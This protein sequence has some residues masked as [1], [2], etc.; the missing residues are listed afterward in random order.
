MATKTNS[1]K[2]W[3]IFRFRERFELG[4]DQRF[5][6]KGPLVYARDYVSA[7]D[8]ESAVYLRQMDALSRRQNGLELEGAWSRIRRAAS[9]RSRAYR[10]YLL[11]ANDCPASDAEIARSVLFCEPRRASRILKSL[12]EIGL[13]EQVRCPTFDLSE[14]DAPK[15]K[16]RKKTSQPRE[17]ANRRNGKSGRAKSVS[18]ESSENLEDSRT[19]LRAEKENGKVSQK[20][21]NTGREETTRSPAT[22]PSPEPVDPKEPEGGQGRNAHTAPGPA[23]SVKSSGPPAAVPIGHVVNIH[24]FDADAF[25]LEVFKILGI[26]KRCSASSTDGKSEWKSFAKWLV[27]AKA[28]SPPSAWPQLRERGLAKARHIAKNA[29]NAKNPGALWNSIVR[30]KKKQKA[31][32]A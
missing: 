22:T 21:R 32:T 3:H 8:D 1:Q 28:N 25:G 13:L 15:A 26:D 29:K 2:V 10:G 12:A 14:N 27:K 16:P 30:G 6:R 23:P 4:D 31:K 11:A 9:A 5:C 17:R 24:D 7:S 20:E 18:R 19:P